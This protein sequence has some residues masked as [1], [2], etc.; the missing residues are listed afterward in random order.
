[1]ER[2]LYREKSKMRKRIDEAI[3]VVGYKPEDIVEYMKRIGLTDIPL[4]RRIKKYVYWRKHYGK[5]YKKYLEV[6]NMKLGMVKNGDEIF[7][8]SL[9]KDSD[10]EIEF[11]GMIFFQNERYVVTTKIIEEGENP[12]IEVVGVYERIRNKANM[13]K[14]EFAKKFW[15]EGYDLEQISLIISKPVNWV[16]KVVS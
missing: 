14:K 2:S 11:G 6:N 12:K 7:Y 4:P 16:K 8:N 1:M 13:L 9:F 10:L 15:Q 5:D 3:N